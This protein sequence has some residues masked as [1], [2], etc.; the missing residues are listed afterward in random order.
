MATSATTV[1]AAMAARA[2]RKVRYYFTSR[3]AFGSGS[4]VAYDPPTRM[5]RRQMEM[6]LRRGVVRATSDG[7]FW[8]DVEAM[9][10]EEDRR[11]AQAVLLLK[12]MIGAIFVIAVAVAV[13]IALH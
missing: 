3:N 12:I 11:R 13:A 5:H 8:I 2:R 1:I 7:R 10:L 9:Q 4:A 6:L